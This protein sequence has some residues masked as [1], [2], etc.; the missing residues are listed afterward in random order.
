MGRGVQQ[1]NASWE[2]SNFII[3]KFWA[4]SGAQTPLSPGVHRCPFGKQEN[5]S[6][7]WKTLVA[8]SL[9]PSSLCC[10]DY[11]SAYKVWQAPK[12]LL[13]VDRAVETPPPRTQLDPPPLD[14][15]FKRSPPPPLPRRA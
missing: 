12:A 1:K 14:T 7:H 2:K 5:G 4:T 11:V 8:P 13:F 6:D 15:P 10:C 9:E 3:A